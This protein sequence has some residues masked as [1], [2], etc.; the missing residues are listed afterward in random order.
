MKTFKTRRFF[1]VTLAAAALVAGLVASSV[2][3]HATY[4]CNAWGPRGNV[5]HWEP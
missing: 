3:S 2:P 1:S 4:Y 5:C